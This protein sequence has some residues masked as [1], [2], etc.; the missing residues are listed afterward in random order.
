MLPDLLT[1]LRFEE[2]VEVAF[3]HCPVVGITF[4]HLTTYPGSHDLVEKS[5]DLWGN[6][7]HLDKNVSVPSPCR[8]T[9]L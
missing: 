5:P 3:V 1:P 6:M 8:S 2:P 9:G 7:L 4:F